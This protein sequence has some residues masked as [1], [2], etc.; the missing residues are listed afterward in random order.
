MKEKKNL[1]TT[2]MFGVNDWILWTYNQ[3]TND[4]ITQAQYTATKY[5]RIQQID[6]EKKKNLLTDDSS[7]KIDGSF[8]SVAMT[9]P[10]EAA[11]ISQK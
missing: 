6:W 8:F 7:T 4:I 10:L 9:T 2:P 3:W 1:Y 11:T 5:K